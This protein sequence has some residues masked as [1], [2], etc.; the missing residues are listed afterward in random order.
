MS[1]PREKD[2]SKVRLRSILG[3]FFN[4]NNNEVN[5]SSSSYYSGPG[6]ISSPYNTVHRI[7]VGYD[8]KKFTGL[9][10][11]WMDTLLRDIS[12][13]DQKKNPSAVVSALKFYAKTVMAQEADK[14]KFMIT[15]SQLP[16]DDENDEESMAPIQPVA[17]TD[18]MGNIKESR[19]MESDSSAEMST[20]MPA[21]ATSENAIGMPPVIPPR[22]SLHPAAPPLP[23]SRSSNS[24]TITSEGNVEVAANEVFTKSAVKTS[25]R[26]TPP[27][28]PP[29][30]ASFCASFTDRLSIIKNSKMCNP[31]MPRITFG[32]M[33]PFSAYIDFIGNELAH[34]K[35][36]CS[37]NEQLTAEQDGRNSLGSESSSKVSDDLDS[38]MAVELNTSNELVVATTQCAENVVLEGK[39]T[40]T[41]TGIDFDGKDAA[42]GICDNVQVRKRV[43]TNDKGT[44]EAPNKSLRQKLSDQEILEELK[45]IVNEGNPTDRYDLL[46]KIGIGASGHV[47]TARDKVTGDV[48]AVKRMAFKSQPK[49]ELLLTEIKNLVN[50]IDSF[51]VDADDLWVVM[52]YLEGG[53]L[54]DVVV[55]TELDEGQIAAIL[56][57]HSIIHRDIKSDN[58]LLGMQGAVKLTDFGFCAQIQ[59]G[60]KRATMVGTPYWMAP[61]I[62]NK[63]KY[64]YKVDIWSLGIMALEMLDGEPPY[65]Y[66]TPIKAIYLIA[67]NGKPEVKKKNSLSPEFN[68]FLDRCLCV[69]Q[70]ERADAEELLRHPFIQ[71][72]KPLNSLIAYIRAVK[73]LK[74]QQR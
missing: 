19:D 37:L 17:K 28:L 3:R 71:L 54:T 34:L 1:T 43:Q 41:S 36:S 48:V 60:S 56:K 25:A 38:N 62:V 39:M 72:A 30:P 11:P 10:Q 59:P 14:Q 33:S 73:E 13:A 22:H 55:K 65:L 24:A 53:N 50:Y 52:D 7:H 58:V 26:K 2:K 69:K 29:K 27:P 21:I 70:E 46:Q 6:E 42:N 74:Q 40:N 35:P 67:Q 20:T 45:Q 12:E 9:P 15:N 31:F 18:D 16:F 32:V 8:G 47:Y 5:S 44:D 57:D 51:L 66:E 4:S 49:K 68:D 61:E 64:N 23:P 63:V